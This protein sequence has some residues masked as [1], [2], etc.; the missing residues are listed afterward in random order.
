[1]ILG[2]QDRMA[3]ILQGFVASL[4]SISRLYSDETL[5]DLVMG[6]G[7]KDVEAGTDLQELV[8]HDDFD[9]LVSH[10]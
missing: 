9:V 7:A 5:L 8:V 4:C 6:S 10:G 1:M 3:E 2:V